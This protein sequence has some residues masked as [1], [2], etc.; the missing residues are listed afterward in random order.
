M[1]DTSETKR[2]SQP[3]ADPKP[4][5]PAEVVGAKGVFLPPDPVK[6]EPTAKIMFGTEQN[7][8]AKGRSWVCPYCTF[9]NDHGGQ[10]DI[11][12]MDLPE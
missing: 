2:A 3:E 12:G 4:V 11:C 9:E 10:C 6:F 7:L 8:V 5:L 1:T